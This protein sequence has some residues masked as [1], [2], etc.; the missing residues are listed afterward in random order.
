[1][2]A[3]RW[4]EGPS[5]R[6]GQSRKRPHRGTCE[7]AARQVPQPSSGGRTGPR[8]T[9]HREGANREV[10]S[11]RLPRRLRACPS[12]GLDGAHRLHAALENVNRFI[13]SEEHTSELQSIMRI[14]YAV[15]GLKKNNTKKKSSYKML[16]M[17][18]Y[19]NDTNITYKY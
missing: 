2:G 12:A 13:R 8:R 7:P 18:M 3:F 1:M 14:S 16:N 6:A 10:R 4:R 9:W 19:K 17:H 5:R 15:F 11:I